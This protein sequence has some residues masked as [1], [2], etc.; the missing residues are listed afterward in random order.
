MF[1][2][3]LDRAF[4]RILKR[5]Q[6]MP[7]VT[8]TVEEFESGSAFGKRMSGQTK[9]SISKLQPTPAMKRGMIAATG[10]DE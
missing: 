8:Q 5:A 9:S 6:L 4:Q 3:T 1:K 10:K 2:G 7:K